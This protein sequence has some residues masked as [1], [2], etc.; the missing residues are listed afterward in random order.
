MNIHPAREDPLVGRVDDVGVDALVR[1]DAL[2]YLAHHAR[3]YPLGDAVDADD[4]VAQCGEVVA[5]GAVDQYLLVD[6]IGIREHCS[7]VGDDLV[8]NTEK[9][10]ELI[11]G[12]LYSVSH[13]EPLEEKRVDVLNADAQADRV[14]QGPDV[15]LQSGDV[16][17]VKESFF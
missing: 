8:L 16:V 4:D 13:Y 6:G 5:V 17:I 1:A 3:G 12:G 9:A 2:E 7:W 14:R 11:K 10:M 15:P